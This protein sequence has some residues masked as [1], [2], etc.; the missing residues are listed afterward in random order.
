MLKIQLPKNI[1]GTFIEVNL[2][3]KK[4]L[5]FS[6]YNPR[7]K[8]IINF[9]NKVGIHIDNLIGNYDNL[10]LIGDFNS[11]MEEE[12]MNLQNLIKEPTCFN[13]AKSYNY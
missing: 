10:I 13:C 2:G 11:E 12:Q 4:W 5:L 1:E 6:G 8:L 9:L 7:K 3:S